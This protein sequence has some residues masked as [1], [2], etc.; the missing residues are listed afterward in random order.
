MNAEREDGGSD[1]VGVCFL[2]HFRRRF[3]LTPCSNASLDT[4]TPGSKQ[5]VIR[6][7]F[8]AAS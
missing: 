6:R 1:L 8:D 4:E 5:A 2:I 7:S 3:A